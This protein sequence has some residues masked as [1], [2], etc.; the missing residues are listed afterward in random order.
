MLITVGVSGCSSSGKSTLS[1]LL[2]S[3]FSSDFTPPISQDRYFKPKCERPLATFS[4]SSNFAERSVG[5]EEFGYTYEKLD[6]GRGWRIRGPENDSPAS[7]D[8]S[9][10]V[11]DL[12][13]VKEGAHEEVGRKA[14]VG[15]DADATALSLRYSNLINE[16]RAVVQEKGRKGMTFCFVEG[17]LLFSPPSHPD[18]QRRKLM[19]LL[20]VKIFLLTSKSEAK[21]RRFARNAYINVEDGGLRRPGQMVRSEGYF[22]RVAWEHYREQFAWLLEGNGEGVFVRPEGMSME[23]TVR[24]AVDVLLDVIEGL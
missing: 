10:L 15:L 2:S 11:K 23:E 18:L 4:C 9:S 1:Y 20:D 24:W 5:H 7:M 22:E 6:G 12:E 13:A 21:E 16:M 19:D 8:F 14:P 3:I 17:F